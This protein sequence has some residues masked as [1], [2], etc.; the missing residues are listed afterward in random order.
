MAPAT[1]LNRPGRRPSE[2]TPGSSMAATAT[3]A[4]PTASDNT[5]IFFSSQSSSVMKQLT[6]PFV[7]LDFAVRR[8]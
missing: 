7:V 6:T 5:I 1:A 4:A 3:P 2:L 8:H